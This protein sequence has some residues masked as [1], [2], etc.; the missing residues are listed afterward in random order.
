MAVLAG[1]A[2]APATRVSDSPPPEILGAFEDDYGSSY[3]IDRGAWHH[4]SH[5]TYEVVEWN[6][7]E[8]YLVAR[9]APRNRSDAGLW[10]RID[11]M[12]LEGMSPYTWAYCLSAYNAPTQAA[13]AATRI[14][15]R[16]VPRTGCNGHPF[17]RMKATGSEEDG[18]AF[19]GMVERSVPDPG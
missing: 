9:N 7:A 3:R 13:A 18:L 16:S 19:P 1:C 8:Q 2:S 5:S 4:G 11:W 17:S 14:A 10:T 6:A 15:D 12:P